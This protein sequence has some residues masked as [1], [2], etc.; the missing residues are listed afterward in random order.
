MNTPI[1]DRLAQRTGL[2]RS[3]A[4]S[5]VR[6]LRRA[7][8]MVLVLFLVGA[9]LGRWVGLPAP[10]KQRLLRELANRGLEVEVKKI[11]LDPFG[12]LVARDLVV[13]R[14]STRGE[15][16]LRVREVSLTPNWLAWHAGEPFLSGA[17]L[18][19]AHI[20]WPLGEGVEAEARAKTRERSAI[21]KSSRVSAC[22]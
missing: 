1:L 12:G 6:W 5:A 11:T 17:R 21:W 20:S 4:G 8:V 14:D 7:G 3:T 18:R 13:Y 19:D 22:A 15:E 10:W 9:V 16:R 2:K